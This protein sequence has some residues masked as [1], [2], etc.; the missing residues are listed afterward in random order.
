MT[1]HFDDGT[2]QL[3]LGDRRAIG[4]ERDEAYSGKAAKR[5]QRGVIAFEESP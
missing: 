2:C 5:M 3:F 4:V 1:P